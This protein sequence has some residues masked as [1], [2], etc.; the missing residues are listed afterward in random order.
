[1]LLVYSFWG[2]HL[3]N[4]EHMVLNWFDRLFRNGAS[5]IKSAFW[6]ED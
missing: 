2:C 4:V 6:E 5:G 3:F 1:M